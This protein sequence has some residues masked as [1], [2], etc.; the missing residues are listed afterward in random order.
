MADLRPIATFK[1][2]LK[3]AVLKERLNK[4]GMEKEGF[5][6]STNVYLMYLYEMTGAK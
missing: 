3:M 5:E 4:T 2:L 1:N 6:L